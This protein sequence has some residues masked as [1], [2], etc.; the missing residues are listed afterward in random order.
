VPTFHPR[1]ARSHRPPKPRPGNPPRNPDPDD[2]PPVEEPPQ[3]IQPPIRENPPP[4]PMQAH[5]NVEQRMMVNFTW[6]KDSAPTFS[7][8]TGSRGLLLLA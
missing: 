8:C 5:R 7:S 4:P 2:P 6:R 3:P 1:T